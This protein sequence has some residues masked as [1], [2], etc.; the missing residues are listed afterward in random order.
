M[1]SF[2]DPNEALTMF[3]ERDG[4]VGGSLLGRDEAEAQGFELRAQGAVHFVRL[5]FCQRGLV[6]EVEGYCS[7]AG[8][9]GDLSCQLLSGRCPVGGGGW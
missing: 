7:R 9:G 5:F 1:R 6:A 4:D 8:A 3:R 2:S